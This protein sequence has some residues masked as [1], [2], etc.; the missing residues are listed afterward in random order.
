MENKGFSIVPAII[1]VVVIGAMMVRGCD[2]GPFNRSRVVGLK[3][4]EEVK[5]GADAFRDVLS[6]ER[7]NVLP[8]SAPIVGVVRRI[9]RDLA[10]AS[11]KP[12]VRKAIGL[13][14]MEFEWQYEVVDS[15]QVNAFCLPGGK[16]VV[17]T[18]ILPVCQTEAGLATVMGHEIGHALARHGAERIAQTKM[19]QV[20]QVALAASVSRMD[21]KQRAGL[22]AAMG[23]GS[24]VGIL[25]PFSRAHESE[26][27]HIGLI[28]MARAGY[29]PSVAPE[30]WQ[31]MDQV[32]KGKRQA[33]FLSTHPDPA[34]RIADLRKWQPEAQ[35]FYQESTKQ[36]D[37]PLPGIG[38][39][40]VR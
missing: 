6:K 1:G 12:D 30:F 17:Y 4:E 21:P 34:T 29:D 32:G 31:R 2:Q 28:L 3:P 16:V 27:D 25:L 37:V 14:P 35:K 23:V 18:G 13:K 38:R 20:G 8:A 10:L 40:R 33:E 19:V 36:R 5:L 26:A 24:Q 15:Q 9:G 7:G 22:M 39:S 11:E